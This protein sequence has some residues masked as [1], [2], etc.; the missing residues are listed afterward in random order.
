MMPRSQRAHRQRS[1]DK[2]TSK[3]SWPNT[4]DICR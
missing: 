3:P 4:L 2:R 1:A